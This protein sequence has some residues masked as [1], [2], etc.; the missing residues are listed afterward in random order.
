M[1][2][3]LQEP[4]RI[5]PR[6]VR[7]TRVRDTVPG[8]GLP[9]AEYSYRDGVYELRLYMTSARAGAV[10]AVRRGESEFA[11]IVEDPVIVLCARFGEEIPWVAATYKGSDFEKGIGYTPPPPHSPHES[12]ALLNV[13]LIDAKSGKIQ[14]ERNLTLW[15]EFS[16]R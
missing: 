12:R 8:N 1:R 2:D 6:T 16:R 10:A 11:L 14:A 4:D 3:L 13:T 7:R 9:R 15:L 5:S